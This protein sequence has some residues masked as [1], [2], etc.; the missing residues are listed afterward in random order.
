M[1]VSRF[2][3]ALLFGLLAR[4][5]A[6]N[7][8]RTFEALRSS[9]FFQASFFLQH[10]MNS[11]FAGGKIGSRP[12]HERGRLSPM[13]RSLRCLPSTCLVYCGSLGT[14]LMYCGTLGTCLV[15][16]GSL[17]TCLVYCGSLG[18]CPVYCGNLGTCLV[19]CGSLGTCLVYC[20]SL[21]TCLVHCG[22]FCRGV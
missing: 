15:Y 20:G 6:R 19:Y 11:S 7:A 10:F 1:A 16:C 12:F 14:C 21:G 9:N 2:L 18:T 8:A 4:I 5:R 13:A 3:G 22:N 17:G